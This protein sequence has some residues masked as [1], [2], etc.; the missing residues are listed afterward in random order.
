MIR[1]TM[2]GVTV[3]LRGGRHLIIA[4]TG[5]RESGG[6]E[7]PEEPRSLAEKRSGRV[8]TQ[9]DF[10]FIWGPPVDPG[11]RREGS[12]RD[13]VRQAREIFRWEW[14]R[15]TGGLL[16]EPRPKRWQLEGAVLFRSTGGFLMAEE[17]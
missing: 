6:P 17:D 16:P 8:L 3:P 12:F 1:I 9:H 5:R 14:A 4:T 11:A 13:W 2:G 15:A 10:S 7:E